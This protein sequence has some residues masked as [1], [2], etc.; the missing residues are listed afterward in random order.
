M[1]EQVPARGRGRPREAEK[2]EAIRQATWALLVSRGYDGLTFEAV[3]E[4]AGIS[5][6]T[7]YRRFATKAELVADALYQTSRRMERETAVS[8]DPAAALL[9]HVRNTQAFMT[10]ARGRAV[11]TITESASRT[12]DL[13]RA[14]RAATDGDEQRVLDV[15]SE[16]RPQAPRDRLQFAFNVIVGA[17]MYHQAMRGGPMP[18]NGAQ[19]LVSAAMAVLDAPE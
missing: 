17:L 7:L 4:T 2:D 5:R 16:L 18:A 14:T 1:T 13:A 6:T 8:N 3:A 19:A 11:V 12:P 9:T 15:L 10:G